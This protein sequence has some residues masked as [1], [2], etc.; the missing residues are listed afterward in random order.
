MRRSSVSEE[1]N[2]DDSE[3]SIHEASA[4]EP[5]SSKIRKNRRPIN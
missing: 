4:N 2:L 3:P 1:E 5:S